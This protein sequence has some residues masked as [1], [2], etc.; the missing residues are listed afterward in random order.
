MNKSDSVVKITF[1]VL[2]VALF[3]GISFNLIG[4]SN[5]KGIGNTGAYLTSNG[6]MTGIIQIAGEQLKVTQNGEVADKIYF[7]VNYFATDRNYDYDID[8]MNTEKVGGSDSKYLRW[9]WTA[10]VDG[11]EENINKYVNT[12]DTSETTNKQAYLVKN[13]YYLVDNDYV[14]TKLAPQESISILERLKFKG[15]YDYNTK[16]YGSVLDKYASGSNIQI[17]L[18]VQGSTDD[19]EEDGI[20]DDKWEITTPQAI[21]YD[22]EGNE[23]LRTEEF[24]EYTIPTDIAVTKSITHEDTTLY[25]QG[26]QITNE[27]TGNEGGS[28]FSPGETVVLNKFDRLI[29]V[30]GEDEDYSD[31]LVFEMNDSTGT[32][33]VSGINAGSSSGSDSTTTSIEIPTLKAG[34]TVTTI[35][36]Y[37]FYKYTAL[38]TVTLGQSVTSI[39]NYAFSGCTNLQSIEIPASVT[40]IGSG[41]FS[42]CS[43]LGTVTFADNSQLTSIGNSAFQN[44]TSLQTIE[45]PAGVT[46][47]GNRAFNGCTN[48][49]TV[50]FADNSQLT[51][52]GSDAFWN[53][54]SLQ[55]IEIP[56][57]VTSIG[58]NAFMNTTSCTSINVADGNPNYCDEDGVLY[59]KNKT[60][61][62]QYPSGKQVS[63]FTI[64]ASVTSIGEYAFYECSNP[65]TV[66][67]AEGSQL[68]SI[69]KSAFYECKSLQSIEIP[70]GLTSIGNYVFYSTSLQTIEIPAGVTSI[71]D[72]A[73]RACSNLGTVTFADN[74]QLTS[75]GSYAFQNC[76]S[77]QSIEMPAG[78]TSIG[79]KA[80]FSCSNLGTVTFADNSQLTSIG[81]SAF[82]NCTSLQT[83]E[84]PASVTSIGEKVFYNTTSCTSI[85][86]ADGNPNYC[87][88]DGV[89]YDKNKT[90]LIQYPLGKQASTYII[91]ASVTSIGSNMFYGCSNLGT[92]TFAEGSQ[93]TSIGNS[94][95]YGCKS[96]Q[97]IEIPASVTS[98]GDYAFRGCS[99]LQTIELPVG[100]TSIG[101]FAFYNCTKLTNVNFGNKDGW[102]AGSTPIATADLENTGTAAKYLKNTYC[103]VEWIR[104]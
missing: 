49:G 35:Q 38:Q 9:K 51:S 102:T 30:Y 23:L 45:I 18:T 44:C 53:C 12:T 55:T 90:T 93:L 42:G 104:S 21:I 65:G 80:F 54:T 64:P 94:A 6:G 75:I 68:T 17:Y 70:A 95:F 40:G 2:L 73:F 37:G 76:T 72:S 1:V 22:H 27:E 32:Y 89:L 47:I 3:F 96:L 87:D 85:N 71:G 24:G 5:K 59:D 63:T 86:V 41:A 82:Q 43:N 34:D 78:V 97:T 28:I 67:F 25:F 52:I 60:T 33:T 103:S 13:W 20:D 79:E 36:N 98:I 58:G 101:N 46:S 10:V 83:I 88:E 74:S 50:T 66:T 92:V 4:L 14:A 77:L 99:S 48:L 62:I 57:G 61:L 29:P 81:N 91:P 7:N 39:G 84:I 100:V 11:V 16:E 56:A 69:G 26:F 31:T 15:E 19:I 8:L